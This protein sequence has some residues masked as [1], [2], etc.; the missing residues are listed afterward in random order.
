MKHLSDEELVILLNQSNTHAFS[1]IF[2]RYKKDLLPFAFR[3]I[4]DMEHSKDLIH[5]AFTILWTKREKIYI[6]GSIRPLLITI[7]KNKILDFYKHQKISQQYL[8][9]FQSYLENYKDDT[10][11]LV[12]YNDLSQRIE[13]E[14]LTLPEKIRVVFELS[15]KNH[16]NR[17]EISEYLNVPEESVKTNIRRALKI[18]K[19]KFPLD[20][21]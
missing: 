10:D 4:H 18:L 13:N 19:G 2:R 9:N 16:M 8:D 15:R 6:E 17:K 7:I 3:R 11:H 14:I 12:R 1:E 21:M 5:D 20:K